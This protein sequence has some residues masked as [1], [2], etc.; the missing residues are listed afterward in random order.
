MIEYKTNIVTTDLDKSLL[1][2]LNKEER[3][4]ILE[5]ITSIVFLQNLISVDRK[6]AKDLVRWD[7]P[8]NDTI[9]SDKTLERK[10]N[11][12]GRIRLDFADPHIMEDTA[13]FREAALHFEEHGV[14]TFLK[15]DRNPYSDYRKFWDRE[16]ERCWNGM[17]RESDGEW[18]TGQ[19][20]F[21]LN[22][23]PV[24]KSVKRKGS[25]RVDRIQGLPDFYDGDYWFFHYIERA[26]ENGKHT[27]TLKKRGAGYS[28]KGAGQLGRNFILGESKE[29]DKNTVSLAIANEKEY[30]TKDGVLNKFIDVIDFCSKHTPFPNRRELKDSWQT[31]HWQM[32]WKDNESGLEKGNKNQVMGVTLKND[33]EKARGKRAIFILWEE[34]GKFKDSLTAWNIARPSVEDGEYVFGLMSAFGTGGTEG[35][36]F[37]GLRELFYN[38]KGYNVYQLDNVYDKN[39]KAGIKCAFFHAGYL[40]QM[41]YM[42]KEGNSDVITSI[43]SVVRKRIEIKYNSSEA[44]TLTQTIAEMALTPQEA[45]MKST[46]SM[47]PTV[48]IRDYLE[49]SR[50]NYNR[51]I[52]DQLVGDLV[53]KGA[54]NIEFQPNFEKTAIRTY[55]MSK[56]NTEGAV[57]I[58]APPQIDKTTKSPYGYRYIAGI[59]PID[60]DYTE[61]GSLGCIVIY[62]LWNEE[63]VAD[64]IGRPQLADDFY[65]ICRRLLL[66][67]N[68]VA[69]Y[70]NNIKGLFGYFNNKTALNL[71]CDTPSYL[72]DVEEQ[73]QNLF[74]NRAKG[75][76]ASA[77]II[78]DGLRLQKTSMLSEAEVLL[79]DGELSKTIRLRKIKS[80]RYLEELYEFNVDGNFDYVSAMNMVMILRQDRIKI[81]ESISDGPKEDYLEEDSFIRDN[82]DSK[83]ESN[84]YFDQDKEKQNRNRYEI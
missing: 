75:T 20:Y 40:N 3:E 21:Y 6:F 12:K 22:F 72:R 70:E 38:P 1:E 33:P 2:S 44:H 53:I 78:A 46:G 68:A 13:Y 64:Y 9:L 55:N 80:L 39:V 35:A 79:P 15:P 52:E 31:M 8:D 66:Y 34:F 43:L 47:F 4:T 25:A 5:Y 37:K 18:I 81:T 56:V 14:Y 16:I 63:I 19:H 48:D 41:G 23:S 24:M 59:D 29:A 36:S 67:Y 42:D 54:G 10:I 28:L 51:F 27:C 45:I 73:K 62:D 58:Y 74:G 69:N 32:G 50:V 76:R 71:L 77:G 57:V 82:Y 11:N 84:R 60:N 17:T 26:R 65:E 30:L 49:E 7:N 61:T 83:L